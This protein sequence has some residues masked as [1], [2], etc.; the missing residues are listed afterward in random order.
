MRHKLAYGISGAVV[1]GGAIGSAVLK[2]RYGSR[3]GD[4]TKNGKPVLHY[5]D[6]KSIKPESLS[7][8]PARLRRPLGGN[9]SSKGNSRNRHVTAANY[10][11][12]FRDHKAA[13]QYFGDRFFVAMGEY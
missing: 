9:L 4:W 2:R 8:F 12:V 11:M 10:A 13:K 1:A 7:T 3:M 5:D 6:F